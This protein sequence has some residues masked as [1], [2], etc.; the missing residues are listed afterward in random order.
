MRG[1]AGLG[2]GFLFYFFNRFTY[3]LGLSSTLPLLLA[4]WAP[5]VVAALVSLAYLLHREDG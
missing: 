3:A 2:A 5:T 1:V 4:A